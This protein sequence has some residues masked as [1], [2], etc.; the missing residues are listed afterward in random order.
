[1]WP[2]WAAGRLAA[3]HGPDTGFSL[4]CSQKSSGNSH[5]YTNDD[6]VVTLPFSPYD[7]PLISKVLWYIFTPKNRTP[8]KDRH[9]GADLC[10]LVVELQKCT[11]TPSFQLPSDLSNI[12]SI[13]GSWDT[14]RLKIV[15]SSIENPSICS[16]WGNYTY[17][18]KCLS[19]LE[20]PHIYLEF[21]ELRGKLIL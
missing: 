17:V 11:R 21:W 7:Y 1:M 10:L 20:Q 6:V 4:E 8:K 15:S 16:C 18:L 9:G 3:H 5:Y 2:S 12:M 19:T 14:Y 13:S